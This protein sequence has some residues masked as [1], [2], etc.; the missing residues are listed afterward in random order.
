MGA[1]SNSWPESEGNSIEKG[2]ILSPPLLP[3][4]SQLSGGTAFPGQTRVVSG[5]FAGRR[6]RRGGAG[7]ARC[8]SRFFF[9]L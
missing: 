7:V 4:P 1:Q 3:P 8:R 6:W 5:G 9:L 2:L